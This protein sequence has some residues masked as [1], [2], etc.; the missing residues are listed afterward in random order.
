MKYLITLA[1]LFTSLFSYGYDR[2]LEIQPERLVFNTFNSSILEATPSIEKFQ[3][4]LQHPNSI[5]EHTKIEAL[6]VIFNDHKPITI[7]DF[8]QSTQY[9]YN[10]IA[11]A[12]FLIFKHATFSVSFLEDTKLISV[13]ISIKEDF[14]DPTNTPLFMSP[15]IQYTDITNNPI[16]D[17]VSHKVQGKRVVLKLR[18]YPVEIMEESVIHK[19]ISISYI[20]DVSGHGI[21]D[22]RLKINTNKTSLDQLTAND[23]AISLSASE[24]LNSNGEVE[25]LWVN[26]KLRDGDTYSSNIQ[27]VFPMNLEPVTLEPITIKP[28]S[29]QP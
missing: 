1:L 8:T 13:Q 2:V 5:G 3:I 10:H 21:E 15:P 20:I 26:T 6:K 29:A 4:K 25:N 16:A 24:V 27:T 18:K 11:Q 7:R 17:V 9:D 14:S 22:F 12:P 23:V 19:P 28:I